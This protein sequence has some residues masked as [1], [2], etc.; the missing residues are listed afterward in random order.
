[1]TSHLHIHDDPPFR[2]CLIP[3]FVEFADV[4]SAVVHDQHQARLVT[5]CPFKH[6]LIT[7]GVAERC[8]R[9]PA[10]VLVNAYGLTIT[11]SRHRPCQLPSSKLLAICF[12]N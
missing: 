6:L 7:I 12:V 3:G 1:M 10:N 9:L 4:R 5:G 2:G 8:D 11:S